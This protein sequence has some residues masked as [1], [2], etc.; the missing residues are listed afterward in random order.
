VTPADGVVGV[1]GQFADDVHRRAGVRTTGS[2]PSVS[3]TA[4][5]R[6]DRDAAGEHADVAL[7]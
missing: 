3:A 4:S 1:G 2:E 7:T 6:C 5:S